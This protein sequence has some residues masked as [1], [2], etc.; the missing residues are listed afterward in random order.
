MYE[1]QKLENETNHPGYDY[2]RVWSLK[3]GIIATVVALYAVTPPS[4]PSMPGH[5][6]PKPA[7]EYA[8]TTAAGL[9]AE[10]VQVSIVVL[11]YGLLIA[12]VVFAQ[13]LR[14]A[15]PWRHVSM[16][17]RASRVS[18]EMDAGHEGWRGRTGGVTGGVGRLPREG[19][20]GV[21]EAVEVDQGDCALGIA[22]RLGAGVRG[23][24]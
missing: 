18:S 17:G 14:A 16:S 20:D 1:N 22:P 2:A 6:C 24:V 5:E 15:Q 8:C 9:V 3:K 4:Y 11:G 13:P 21:R 10:H 19:D 7:T 12:A 23:G